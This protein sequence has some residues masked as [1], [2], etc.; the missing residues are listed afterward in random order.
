MRYFL[1]K[2]LEI[3]QLNFALFSFQP[4]NIEYNLDDIDSCFKLTITANEPDESG[5]RAAVELVES[6]EVLKENTDSKSFEKECSEYK[7]KEFLKSFNDKLCGMM[8][9]HNQTTEIYS[10]CTDLM[11]NMHEFNRNLILEN[12]L[13]ALCALKSSTKFVTCKLDEFST[14]HKRDKRLKSKELFVSPKE[15]ALSLRYNMSKYKFSEVAVPRLIQCKFHYIS[16]TQSI[17]SLFQ[18]DDFRKTYFEFNDM[19]NRES[20]ENKYIDFSSGTRFKNNELFA[21]HPESLQ[22]ELATDDFD[23][24]NAVGSKA[25]IHKLF[26]VYFSIKNLPSK[27][28]SKL[29]SISVASLCY[30]ND[31]NTMYT[32]FNDIWH[33]VVNDIAQIENGIDIGGRIVKGSVTFVASDNLG[34]N[35]AL[36]FVRNFSKAKYFCRFCTCPLPETKTLCQ[37]VPPKLRTVEHYNDQIQLIKN[38]T[39]VD[40]NATYGIERYCVLND[41]KYF[42]IID[43]MVPD[44]MHDIDEGVI[45]FALRC[46]FNYLMEKNVFT[47]KAIKSKVECFD[48]GW[49]NRRNVPTN[50][51]LQKKTL[52]LNAMQVH[53]LFQNIPFIFYNERNYV[54]LK[55]VW[56]SIESLLKIKQI[57]NSTEIDEEDL[58]SLEHHIEM[59]LKSIQV[60]FKSN[61]I[62]KHHFLTHYVSLIRA[63][64]PLKAMSMIRFE[65]NHKQLKSYAERS[66]NFINITK[67]IT[68]RHQNHLCTVDNIY[69][70]HHEHGKR[71]KKID[72]KFFDEWKS[73]FEAQNIFTSDNI[74]E[75]PFLKYN[76]FD[77]RKGMLIFS[78]KI[79]FEINRVLISESDYYFACN[80]YEYIAYDSFL[81]SIEIRKCDPSVMSL[82]KFSSIKNKTVFE[83]NK[84]NSKLYII[85][86]TLD[87]KSLYVLFN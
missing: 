80:Q 64:G 33:V 53:C 22:I 69:T 84:I 56:D 25:T 4:P 36:G 14:R 43:G 73:I 15:L 82:K 3:I 74:F 32:D 28:T 86:E 16:I 11:N 85:L 68:D 1:L 23:L 8:L 10:L 87:L 66:E 31:L 71:A 75:T 35:T 62:P 26:P 40:W 12:N 44:I 77:Y 37:E 55:A 24:C 81:N 13:D 63:N 45:P 59:H 6:I 2:L 41:L 42:H 48:Y 5:S 57:V 47:E 27:F 20:T 51:G 17:I 49:N 46:F 65:A 9:N 70:D 67:T 34:A 29:N 76:I 54:E 39:K 52:G 50:I 60:N 58:R 21:N 30:S 7:M 61:L 38:S 19:S 72:L 79:L 83:L 18:R 78:E